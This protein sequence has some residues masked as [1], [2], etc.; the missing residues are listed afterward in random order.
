[1]SCSRHCIRLVASAP[2][3]YHVDVLS[4]QAFLLMDENGVFARLKEV[5]Q[6]LSD[7]GR[8]ESAIK[9]DFCTGHSLA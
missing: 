1:M 9:L 5:S 4:E 8:V 2:F 3:G 7:C 6:S